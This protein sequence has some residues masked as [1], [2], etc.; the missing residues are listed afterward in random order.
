M[1]SWPEVAEKAAGNVVTWIVVTAAGGAVWLV[2]RVFTNQ[3]QLEMMQAELRQREEMRQRDRDDLQEVKR[4]VKEINKHVL[5]LF[6]NHGG[7]E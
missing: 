2:R 3:K 6:Q 5:T 7:R 1:S 4:D